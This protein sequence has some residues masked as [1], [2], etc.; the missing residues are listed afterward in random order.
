MGEILDGIRS[1]QDLR[2]L[3]HDRLVALAAEIRQEIV[4][5]VAVTGGHLAPS[6]GVVELTVALH[7]EFDSPTD[8]IVWD[9]G[10]QSYAHKLLTGRQEQFCTLRQLGGLSGFPKCGESDHDAF[11]TGH[12]STSVSA[13]LGLAQ[14]RDLAGH[15]HRVVAVIGDGALTGGMAYE[16]LN[17]AGEL[18][19]DLTVILNDNS[20]SIAPNV[21][22]ITSHLNRLRS[23]PVYSRL[24][25]DIDSLLRRIP[26]IGP[27]LSRTVE[28]VKLG[29]KYV[30]LE[31]MLFE[32]LGFTYLGPIDGHDMG[33]L[34]GVLGRARA[35]RGPVLIH[36]VTTKGYGYGPAEKNPAGFHGTGPFDVASGEARSGSACPSFSSVFGQTLLELAQQDD[37]ILAITA[38]MRDGTGLGPFAER[39]PARFFDVGIAEQHAVTFAAGL[40]AGGMRPVVAVY[41]TFMQRAY[42]Q[43]LHDV[44]IQ[45]LPVVLALD[46]A[47]LVGEDGETHH[48]AFDLAYLSHIPNLTVMAPADGAELE[49][50]LRL[51]LKMDGPSAIRYPRGPAGAALGCGG[52]PSLKQLSGRLL[53]SGDDVGIVAVGTMVAPALA[54]ARLLET[55]GISAAVL[56]ARFVKP[57]PQDDI[58]ELAEAVRLLVTVEEGTVAGGFGSGVTRLVN[59]QMTVPSRVLCLGLPDAFCGHGP[60]HDLLSAL[61]LDAPGI[62]KAVV[63]ALPALGTR[64]TRRVGR[65]S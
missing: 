19:T 36:V 6:L 45:Q 18:G 13:A 47:G 51:A 27:T 43:V 46:R 56:D 42:D 22:A 30:V 33:A 63:E 14:A 3:D 26:R 40:A 48:G 37:R 62:S 31:G 25:D 59:T 55:A 34:L 28:R 10:H 29:L 15:Q 2:S 8:R 1:P 44:C 50:M 20:M 38:A 61:G 65:R 7:R 39:F 53:S 52:Q 60:S 54:A 41:S 17:N 4:E 11:N 16:A 23:E 58:L 35:L 12:S 5:T 57:L 49:W 64:A 24:R 9:V 32:Q 21:G